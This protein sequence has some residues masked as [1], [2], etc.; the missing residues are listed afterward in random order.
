MA[1]SPCGRRTRRNEALPSVYV[2]NPG[3]LPHFGKFRKFLSPFRCLPPT[4]DHPDRCWDGSKNR[5]IDVNTK[6]LA[7]LLA[8]SGTA[9]CFGAGPGL[10]DK[11]Q[12]RHVGGSILTNFLPPTDCV[13]S[14][15]NLCT[16]GIATGDLR[17]ALGTSFLGISGNVFHVHH[18]WVTES[19]DTIFLNDAYATNFPT[20]DP[21]NRVLADY[22]NGIDITGGTGPF[23][24]ATGTIFSFGAADLNLGH[25]TFRYEGTVCFRP[26]SG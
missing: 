10:A 20:A 24:G 12:C 1:Q 21:N 19:G 14:F 4:A 5:R 26:V 7:K 13:G 18:H 8:I 22:L 9:M 15:Q 2:S 6:T 23:E 17:G 25:V 3:I 16:E 11:G